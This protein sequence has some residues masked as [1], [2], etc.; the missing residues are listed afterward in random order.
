MRVAMT[1]PDDLFYFA[2]V[3]LRSYQ[4]PCSG[5]GVWQSRH[6]DKA[7]TSCLPS[8]PCLHPLIQAVCVIRTTQ[9]S[10]F[11]K[12]SPVLQTACGLKW[13]L[14]ASNWKYTKLLCHHRVCNRGF[15]DRPMRQPRRFRTPLN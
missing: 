2:I 8:S 11:L 14:T 12:P 13:Q 4:I 10:I 15:E 9:S 6:R 3:F 5:H 7:S 1:I